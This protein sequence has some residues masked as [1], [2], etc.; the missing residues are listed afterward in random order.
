[1]FEKEKKEYDNKYNEELKKTGVF[2]AFSNEQFEENKTYKNVPDNEYLSI[3]SGGYIHKSNKEKLDY[4]F[5]V[6]EPNLRKDFISKINIEDFI[7]YEL[8]NHEC[9]YTGDYSEVINIMQS[10]YD[11]PTNE[12]FDKVQQVYKQEKS[13][14]IDSFDDEKISI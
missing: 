14:M 1:M 9:F 8:V 2:W 11:L 7:K 5:K 3:G 13:N 6:T 4:F 12:L 10:Y